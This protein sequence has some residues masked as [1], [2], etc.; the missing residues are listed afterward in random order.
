MESQIPWLCLFSGN[1]NCLPLDWDVNR[2]ILTWC[3]THVKNTSSKYLLNISVRKKQQQT[4]YSQNIEHV[5]HTTIMVNTTHARFSLSFSWYLL[6]KHWILNIIWTA[7]ITVVEY[8]SLT[9]VPL[10]RWT[11]CWKLLGDST[12]VFNMLRANQALYMLK[13][14]QAYSLQHSTCFRGSPILLYS[15]GWRIGARFDWC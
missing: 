14:Q 11:A 10:A 8:R 3:T 7:S 1:N 13:S 9:E 5:S 4:V 15:P 6:T 12:S 2:V